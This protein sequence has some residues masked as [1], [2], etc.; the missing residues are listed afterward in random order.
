MMQTKNWTRV[1]TA[2]RGPDAIRTPSALKALTTCTVRSLIGNWTYGDVCPPAQGLR[3]LG[4]ADKGELL[5]E[6]RTVGHH[7]MEHQYAALYEL[8]PVYCRTLQYTLRWME[9]GQLPGPSMPPLEAEA[10]GW[11]IL[12]RAFCHARLDPAKAP[13]ELYELLMMDPPYLPRRY[14]RVELLVEEDLK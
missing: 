5:H 1:I 4:V 3:I 7:F 14:A 10:L 2:T 11:V 12:N 8:C 6:E 9:T 13:T